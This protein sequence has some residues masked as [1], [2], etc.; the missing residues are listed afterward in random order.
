MS[1]D[2]YHTSILSSCNI[3]P[4]SCG[5]DRSVKQGFCGETCELH[6]AAAVVHYGEEPPVTGTGGSGAVFITGCN[7]ACQFCQNYQ[8]SREKMGRTVDE[9]EFVQICLT[10]Q[11]KGVENINIITGSHIVP[12]LIRG[13][14]EAKAA[15]LI[16]P[17]FWNSSAYENQRTIF[18][19]KET[20]D[21]YL[22]DLKTLD[23][24]TAG[25][26]FNAPDYP[27]RAV[28]A[29]L[30]MM[31]NR[32]LRYNDAGTILVSGVIIR[33]LVIPGFL[34]ST[35]Q[36]LRWFAENA[37]GQALLSIMT[38]YTP[39]AS[40]FELPARRVNIKEYSTIMKWLEEF[41]IDDGFCQEMSKNSEQFPDFSRQ[42]PFSSGLA[43]PIWHWRDGFIGF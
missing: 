5:V 38:Q 11:K 28:E 8:I 12:V 43:T 24:E 34:E 33:H 9:D 14:A 2:I 25:L 13:I 18:L 16:I 39:A 4:R 41:R 7:L 20:V 36:V 27:R 15:G 10:L 19:L 26:F 1:R 21:V 31:E 32:K 30:M 35:R 23:P 29:I 3:C 6:I 17:V 42:N 22:P 37:K 40:F